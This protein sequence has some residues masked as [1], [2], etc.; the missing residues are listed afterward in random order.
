M[1]TSDHFT[2]THG[3][4]INIVPLQDAL[5]PN[6]GT[7]GRTVIPRADGGSV[8]ER[9]Q[10]TTDCPDYLPHRDSIAGQPN[11]TPSV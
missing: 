9:W 4:Y 1:A 7:C 3:R 5:G 11:Y 2:D 10:H 6:C 8:A